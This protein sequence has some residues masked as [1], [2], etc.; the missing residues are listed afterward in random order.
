VSSRPFDRDRSGL[1]PAEGGAMLVLEGLDHALARGATPLAE[2]TGYGVSADASFLVAPPEDGN[3][4]ARAMK[5]ALADAGIPPE[6]VD[7]VSAHATA[8]QAGDIA[9]T[10]ALRTVFGE[11]AYR[12]P[13]T[14]M[15]S[16]TGHLLGGSGGLELV[17]AVRMIGSSTVPPTI[18]LDH[19]DPECDLDYV[20]HE[21]REVEVNLLMKNSFG[22]GGQNAVL[23]LSRYDG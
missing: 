20:P 8:T 7:C 13:V 11:H 2:I 12:M 22:F 17:A 9:E 15:K 10:R 4:G 5:A 14:A 6:A 18:N 3:G 21:A 23:I 19:P 16:Q 1:V